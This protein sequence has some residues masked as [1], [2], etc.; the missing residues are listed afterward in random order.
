MHK[1]RKAL[2]HG[3]WRWKRL[4]T[5]RNQVCSIASPTIYVATGS[6]QFFRSGIVLVGLFSYVP[7]WGIQL[8][9]R[10]FDPTKGLTGG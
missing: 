3:P 2:L 7:M 10:E 5:A 1:H 9:F 6:W 4:P 8:A